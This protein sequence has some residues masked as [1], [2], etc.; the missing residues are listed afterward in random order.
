MG[1][2][3]QEYRSRIGSFYKTNSRVSNKK[4]LVIKTSGSFEQYLPLLILFAG[5]LSIYCTPYL[6]VPT[7]LNHN[8]P[9]TPAMSS[10]PAPAPTP[11]RSPPA[12]PSASFWLSN[13]EKNRIARATTGNR[14]NRG[15]EG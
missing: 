1:V 5:L 9:Y 6:T 2:T 7:S 15:I 3:L 8:N 11:T 13:K 4:S 10:R 12:S 14:E